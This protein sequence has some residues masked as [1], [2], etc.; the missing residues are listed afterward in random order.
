MLKWP[1]WVLTAIGSILLFSAF[2]HYHTQEKVIN[3]EQAFKTSA[4]PSPS[5]SPKN[6]NYAEI[7]KNALQLEYR[8]PQMRLPDLRNTLLYVGKNM[9]P[10]AQGSEILFFSLNNAPFPVKSR[11][12]IYLISKGG[13][14]SAYLLSPDNRPT[15]LWFQAESRPNGVGVSVRVRDEEGNI[16][17]E[18]EERAELLLSE[19]QTISQQGK[20]FMLDQFKADPALFSRQKAKWYG[21]DVFLDDHGGK[22]FE[23]LLGKQRIQF[24]EGDEAYIIH[25]DKG[26]VM[27]WKDGHWELPKKGEPTQNYPLAKVI[28]VE[29]RLLSFELFDVAGRSKVTLNLVKLQD[30]ANLLPSI[31]HD[32]QFIGARTKMHSMFK[33]NNKREIVGPGDWFLH[34]AAGW[35]KIKSSKEI[36]AYVNDEMPGTLLVIDRFEKQNENQWLAATLY[37]LHRSKS[38]AVQIPLKAHADEKVQK[39]KEPID[40]NAIPKG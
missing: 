20:G 35:Q 22:D 25:L 38:D 19:N 37:N 5:F 18:P 12:K 7:G 14:Q 28:K 40:M 17:Q 36:D 6:S 21:G 23:E 39:Q 8:A 24:G 31:A 32:F 27:I 26:D 15:S 16:V 3:P 30:S 13:P 1:S 34:T 29:D 33:V 10:D 2:W 9:R 4:M 11:E